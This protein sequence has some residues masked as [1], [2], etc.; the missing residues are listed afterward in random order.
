MKKIISQNDDSQAPVFGVFPVNPTLRRR[1]FTIL[2]LSSILRSDKVRCKKN[3]PIFAGDAH[4]RQQ[5]TILP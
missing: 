2:F 1:I 3:H 4:N 5:S